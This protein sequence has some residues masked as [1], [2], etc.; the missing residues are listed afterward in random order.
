[1][2][3]VKKK[4]IFARTESS[5]LNFLTTSTSMTPIKNAK[6]L[7]RENFQDPIKCRLASFEKKSTTKR[8]LFRAH[9]NFSTFVRE[10]IREN[11]TSRQIIHTRFRYGNAYV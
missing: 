9:M 10:K 7:P 2:E 8:L 3:L 6:G 4:K 11:S 1:M 5:T